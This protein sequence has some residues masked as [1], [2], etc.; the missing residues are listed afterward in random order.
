LTITDPALNIDPTTA[1]TWELG[2]AGVDA[3]PV[4]YFATNG[5]GATVLTGANLNELD[6]GDNGFFNADSTS[7][8]VAN[9]GADSNNALG[10]VGFAETG[11]NTGV[12]ESFDAVGNAEFL[13]IAECAADSITLF[14]YGGNTVDMI[15]TYNNASITMGEAGQSWEPAT[16]VTISVNDPDANKNPTSTET[17][18]I[19]DETHVIP[20]IKMGSPLTLAASGT[21]PN[22]NKNDLGKFT[23]N[24][25]SEL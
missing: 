9:T 7:Y 17:L 6:F 11:A 20:T 1:D 5:T 14:S 2:T 16:G 19:G 25:V 24:S 23:R 18:A 10:K 22:I 4:A 12:F 13:T 8:I 15:C 3:T 21:N